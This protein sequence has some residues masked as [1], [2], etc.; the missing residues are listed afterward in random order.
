MMVD[1]SCPPR[2][3]DDR[4]KARQIDP[5]APFLHPATPS[6]QDA[7]EDS[8]HEAL[9]VAH[10]DAPYFYSGPQ[11]VKASNRLRAFAAAAAVTLGL[12]A[13]ALIV[14]GHFPRI[15]YT[16][17]GADIPVVSRRRMA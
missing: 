4:P 11:D 8:Q 9:L 1:A 5:I 14:G 10:H 3:R 6:I 17:Q 13:L 7:R 16:A 12:G 2:Y 15:E